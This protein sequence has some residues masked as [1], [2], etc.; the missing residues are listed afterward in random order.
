MRDDDLDELW[1]D[2]EDDDLDAEL[3]E[4]AWVD[5]PYCGEQVELLLD[6]TG[7]DVQEYV[8]DCEVCCQPWSVRVHVDQEGTPHVTVTTQDDEY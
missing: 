1:D 2:D 6:P 8:E 3:A 4:A 5:C 7:G